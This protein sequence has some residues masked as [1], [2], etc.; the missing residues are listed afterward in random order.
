MRPTP[1]LYT[2]H[3]RILGSAVSQKAGSAKKWGAELLIFVPAE[4]CHGE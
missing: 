4:A 1:K 2:T 3:W